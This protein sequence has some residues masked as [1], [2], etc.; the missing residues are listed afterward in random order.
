MTTAIAKKEPRSMRAWDPFQSLRDE[1]ETLWSYVTGERGNGWMTAAAA[2]PMDVK[3]TPEAVE[4]RL[5]LPG[6]KPE[7]INVQLNNNV[8]TVRGQRVEE[9]KKETATYHRME[10]RVGEF[11]RSVTLPAQVD[12]EKVDA[13]CRD[14]VLT[15]VMQKTPDAKSHQIKVKG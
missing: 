10:R 11:S 2:P 1:V 15:V 13:Q 12:D 9:Q 8:L 14:G 7:D 5:D 3:E 4:V 6:F